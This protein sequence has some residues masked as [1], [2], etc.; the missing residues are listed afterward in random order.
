MK[1]TPNGRFL[2]GTNRGHDSIAIYRLGDDGQLTLLKNEPSL[3]EAPQNL[4]IAG[5]ELLL[6]TNMPAI[7]SPCFGSIRQPVACPRGPA[8]FPAQSLLHHDSA[9]SLAH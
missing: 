6:C 9:E 8:D 5:G 7:T 1:I 4:A 3:G 2:Y